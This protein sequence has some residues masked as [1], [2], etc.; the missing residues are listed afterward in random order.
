MSAAVWSGCCCHHWT[1]ADTMCS[2]TT[3]AADRSSGSSRPTSANAR[4]TPAIACLRRMARCSR[5]ASRARRPMP[6][7]RKLPIDFF[8]YQIVN[9]DSATQILLTDVRARGRIACR[10]DCDG[11]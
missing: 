4:L 5:A 1:S 11:R 8:T 10:A 7:S 2:Q 3:V 6:A 9:I